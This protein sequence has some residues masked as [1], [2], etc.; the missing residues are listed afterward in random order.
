MQGDDWI[1]IPLGDD[2]IE[3]DTFYSMELEG[4]GKYRY[5]VVA[6]Q[7]IQKMKGDWIL[8]VFDPP[9]EDLTR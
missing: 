4:K 6:T 3:L 5:L 9:K 7:I 1:W 2:R 8:Q